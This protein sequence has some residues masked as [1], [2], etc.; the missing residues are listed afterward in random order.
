MIKNN[1]KHSSWMRTTR[2]LTVGEGCSGGVQ[3]VVHTHTLSGTPPT[4]QRHMGFPL[5]STNHIDLFKLVRLGLPSPCRQTDMTE[6]ITFP[7]TTYVGVDHLHGSVMN[8]NGP[9]GG[10]ASPASMWIAQSEW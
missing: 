10:G 8:K 3:G 7:R 2:L 1:R 5:P 6:N 9:G 4:T